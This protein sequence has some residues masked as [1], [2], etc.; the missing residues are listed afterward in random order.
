MFEA[1][2]EA[3]ESD[4]PELMVESVNQEEVALILSGE[5]LLTKKLTSHKNKGY[6]GDQHGSVSTWPHQC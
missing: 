3:L 5:P 2:E 4:E 1:Y 6:D